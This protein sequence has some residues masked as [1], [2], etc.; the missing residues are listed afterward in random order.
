MGSRG[1][2][3]ALAVATVASLL[4]AAP[5]AAARKTPY[6]TSVPLGIT[7]AGRILVDTTSSQV[8][9]TSPPDNDIVVLDLSGNLKTTIRYE[10]GADA[11]AIVGTTLYVTLTTLGAIDEIDTGTLL[12]TKKL[13]TG[14]F[15]PEDLT[16]AGGKLWTATGQGTVELASVDPAALS[17]S[18]TL[19]PS[20]FTNSNGLSGS[21]AFATNHAFNP[22][23]LIAWDPG[24]SPSQATVFDLSSGSPVQ[25]ASNYIPEFRDAVVESDGAHLL[26]SNLDVYNISD[27]S[28]VGSPAGGS[29]MS[30]DWNA[31]DGG[32]AIAEQ[33]AAVG[34]TFSAFEG[35]NLT[36]AFVQYPFNSS[37][38][39]RLVAFSP[40]GSVAY[41]VVFTTVPTP[42][43]TLEIMPIPYVAPAGSPDP[44][45]NVTVDTGVGS[46]TISWTPGAQGSGPITGYTITSSTGTTVRVDPR[47][48]SVTIAGLAP[49]APIFGV[50][51]SNSYGTSAS[52]AAVGESFIG[53]GGTYHALTPARIL[54]TRN[55]IGGFPVHRV[56]ANTAIALQVT[57]RGGVPANG[58]SAVVMNVTVTDPT[59][60]GF[61]TAYPTGSTRPNASNLN[62]VAG[63]TVPNLVEVA[64]SGSGQVSLFVGGASADLVADVEG[65]V[66]DATNS[67]GRA[68]TFGPMAPVRVL[69]TRTSVGGHP[70]KLGPGQSLTVQVTGVNIPYPSPSAVVLN[71]TV[72]NPTAASYLTVYPSYGGRPTTSN[73]NFAAGQTAANRVIV[74]MDGNG[75]V[76]IYNAFGDADVI[77]DVGGVYSSDVQAIGAGFVGVTPQRLIDTR[78]CA[79]C[80]LRAGD[81]LAVTWSPGPGF[82]DTFISAFVLNATV[83]NTT[84]NGYL[85]VFPDNAFHVPPT[86]SDVNYRAGQTVANL[87]PAT[88][89][90]INETFDVYA[91]G[92]ST[93]VI[94]DAEGYYS[95]V[96]SGTC[97]VGQTVIVVNEPGSYHA[98]RPLFYTPRSTRAVVVR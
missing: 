81:V 88:L 71:V 16:Y 4:V 3:C 84:G 54:D 19:Y 40:D 96:P 85:T 86:A 35:S 52:T 7:S 33:N 67:Y 79:Q 74:P 41:G 1:V 21:A 46:A 39:N 6:A 55:G 38:T 14:L 18:V 57:G 70:A 61:V 34:I 83:T 63:L 31:G 93:D 69:D 80:K 11:M 17:P 72:T 27:L 23:F 37:F 76:R 65:W 13:V 97:S 75:Q 62:F 90:T 28:P 10:A 49:G 26:T 36:T 47:Y 8:F 95:N 82:V 12:E 53:D 78:T 48:T 77:A 22:S 58:V 50:A 59:G 29:S 60:A 92:A 91:G 56:S 94:L 64:L 98:P 68:G 51:A 43:T 5:A 42:Q 44:P 15:K 9:V 87:T 45:S 20:A 25:T 32:I 2:A 89:T 66:G 30:V 73:L 24:I